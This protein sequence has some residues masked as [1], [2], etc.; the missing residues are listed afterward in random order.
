MN[1]LAAGDDLY[2]DRSCSAPLLPSPHHF[3]FLPPLTP[4]FYFV[5]VQ[6]TFCPSRTNVY[7]LF[8]FASITEECREIRTFTFNMFYVV[9][10]NAAPT[11]YH[12]QQKVDALFSP[13][14][15]FFASTKFLLLNA[16][17]YKAI[18]QLRMITSTY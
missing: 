9:K 6:K 5:N 16:Q 11:V 13:Q 8:V 4:N 3:A 7:D 10:N 12:L 14:F 18:T 1:I 17:P 15:S 2:L